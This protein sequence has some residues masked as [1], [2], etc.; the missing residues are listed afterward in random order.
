MV[1]VLLIYTDYV[2]SSLIIDTVKPMNHWQESLLVK[3]I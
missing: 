2:K 3:H 1:N